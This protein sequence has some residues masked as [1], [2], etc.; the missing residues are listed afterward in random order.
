LK[1]RT[2]LALALLSAWMVLKIK[3]RRLKFY[4]KKLYLLWAEREEKR[5]AFTKM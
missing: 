1:V 3:F 2:P 5:R 4:L